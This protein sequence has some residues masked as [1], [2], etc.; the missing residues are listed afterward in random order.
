MAVRAG[1]AL[2]WP[3]PSD[4]GFLTPVPAPPPISCQN[5]WVDG[6]L[7]VRGDKENDLSPFKLVRH[8]GQMIQAANHLGGFRD[9]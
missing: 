4:A 2:A 1:Q 8:P 9:V 3:V 7:T 6:S 5:G